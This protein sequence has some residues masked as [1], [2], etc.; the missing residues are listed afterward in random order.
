MNKQE[1]TKESVKR[2]VREKKKKLKE[3]N[4]AWTAVEQVG[5]RQEKRKKLK[6]IAIRPDKINLTKP[7]QPVQIGTLVLK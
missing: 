6:L 3:K 2:Q 7:P 1:D 4:I 5:K